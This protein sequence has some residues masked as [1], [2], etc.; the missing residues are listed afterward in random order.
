MVYLACLP[1]GGQLRPFNFLA[2]VALTT[3]SFE[4]FANAGLDMRGNGSQPTKVTI[5]DDQ[6]SN[7]TWTYNMGGK[8]GANIGPAV[9]AGQYF[10]GN[11]FYIYIH[12]KDDPK[13]DWWLT[14][15]AYKKAHSKGGVLVNTHFDS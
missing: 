3:S 10:E 4:T 11:N 15:S 6:V 14:D 1:M 5:F 12:G 7:V 13:G 9:W 2:V 8:V